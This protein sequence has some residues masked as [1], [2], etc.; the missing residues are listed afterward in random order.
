[1]IEERAFSPDRALS[2]HVEAVR[3]YL[4]ALENLEGLDSPSF[5]ALHE[6]DVMAAM[7]RVFD[8]FFDLRK[9]VLTPRQEAGQE[10]P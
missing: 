6:P 10:A 8:T 7:R 5:S 4:V 2:W 3:K 9:L 1:M